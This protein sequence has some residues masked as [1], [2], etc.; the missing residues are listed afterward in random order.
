MATA[1]VTIVGAYLIFETAL[2]HDVATYLVMASALADGKVLYES[3]PDYSMP[4]NAWIGLLSLLISQ[5][6]GLLLAYT[7]QAVLFLLTAL[8]GGLTGLVISRAVGAT[9]LTGRLMPPLVMALFLIIPGYDF[10]QRDVLFG[11]LAAPL[12]AVVVARHVGVRPGWFL[13]I[14]I[15]G[16]AAIGS[17]LKPQVGLPLLVLG[18]SDLALRCGR[19]QKVARE[20][21]ILASLLFGYVILVQLMYPTYFTQVLPE[22]AKFYAFQKAWIIS[23]L[24]ALEVAAATGLAAAILLVPLLLDRARRQQPIRWGLIAAWVALG[25][26]LAEMHIAQYAALHYHTVPVLLFAAVSVALFACMTIEAGLR[27]WAAGSRRLAGMW[28]IA[29]TTIAVA[30]VSLASLAYSVP[31]TAR[32]DALT[33]PVTKSLR[34]LPAGT[35][36]LSLQLGVPPISPLFAYAD[37]RWSGEFSTLNEISTVVLERAKDR[38]QG[39]PE[40]PYYVALDQHIRHSVLRSLT[41]HTPQIV[42]VDVSPQMRWFE[43]YDK[44]FKLLPWLAEDRAFAAAWSNYE[45]VETVKSFAGVTVAI[46]RRRAPSEY[47]RHP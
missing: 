19:L 7:H 22:A 11:V 39:R 34:S 36:V 13:S 32:T 42:L 25:A 1:L 6:T 24:R 31:G 5:A 21:W 3:F 44:P 18:V 17:S 15:C 40:D 12:V 37:V 16:L 45:Y 9:T 20:L 4:A 43:R 10:G 29:A 47:P 26:A 28:I 8:G 38:A 33:D 41:V 2:N 14:A 27:R 30:I 46:W 35:Y 23:V